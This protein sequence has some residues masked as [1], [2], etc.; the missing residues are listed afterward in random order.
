MTPLSPEDTEK[1]IEEGKPL[2]ELLSHKEFMLIIKCPSSILQASDNFVDVLIKFINL[3]RKYSN[4]E[5]Y[6]VVEKIVLYGSITSNGDGS[7]SINFF[8]N[9]RSAEK[10]QEIEQAKGGWGESCFKDIDSFIGSDE[11][12]EALENE[13]AMKERWEEFKEEYPD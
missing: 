5:P 13:E 9:K 8:I 2:Q 10:D 4:V 7:A 1:Y 11:Y 6:E 12:H 3:R